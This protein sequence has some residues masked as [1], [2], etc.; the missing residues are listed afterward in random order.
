[1]IEFLQSLDPYS[2]PVAFSAITLGVLI[3]VI[4]GLIGRH[5]QE[6]D[7]SYWGPKDRDVNWGP[8]K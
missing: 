5:F 3:G 2:F 6:K 8:P 1:M 7:I 4:V